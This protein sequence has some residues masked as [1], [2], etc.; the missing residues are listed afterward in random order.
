MR[1]ALSAKQ[2]GMPPLCACCGS[3]S[4][5]AVPISSTRVEGKRVIRTKTS[6]WNFPFCGRCCE[7]DRAWPTTSALEVLVLTVLTCGLYL[8]YYVKQR[9][10]A[11][12]LCAPACAPPR[13]AVSYLGWH[14]TVH[15][16]EVASD[17]FAQAFLA[18]NAKKVVGA[19]A[20]ARD[21]MSRPTPSSPPR[22]APASTPRPAAAPPPPTA[23][24]P[25][26]TDLREGFY[27]PHQSVTIAGRK[28]EGPLAYI[29]HDPKTADASTI[30]HSL[31]VAT[32]LGAEPLPY[33]P[34]YSGASPAQRAV[35]LD[36]H[37]SGRSD[38]DV[39][40]GYVFL[41]FYGLE[42]R[43]LVDGCDHEIVQSELRRL[44]GIYGAGNRSFRGYVTNLMAFMV[45]PGLATLPEYTVYSHLAPIAS[46]NQTA[47]AGLLAWLHLQGKPLPPSGAMLVAGSMEGAKRGAVIER[48]RTEL[49]NLFTLRYRER[50]ADGLRLDAAKRPQVI[51]YHPGSPSLLSAARQI[52][53]SIPSVLGRPAQ[54][55]P[56][57]ELWN[58]C[59]ADLKK[60]SFTRRERTDAPLTR[61]AWL[62]L[63][64]ELRAEYDHPDQDTWDEAIRALPR[65][66]ACHVIPAGRLAALAGIE[67]D[68]RVTGARLR[69]AAEMAAVLGYAV[70]PDARVVAKTVPV[71]SELAIWRSEATEVPDATLWKSVHTMLSLTLFVALADGEVA[72][73]EGRT[74]DGL[75]EDLFALDDAMRARVAALR[76]IFMRQPARVTT[77]A[78]KLKE[79]RSPGDLAKI[80]RVLVAIAAVD[81]VIVEGEHKALKNLYKAMD[82]AAS[83]LSAAIVASG[84]R[85]AG[86]DPV[87]VQAARAGL[88][89][90]T[91]PAPPGARAPALDAPA[92]AAIL[93]ETREVALLLSEV[94]DTDEEESVK[95]P[96]ARPSRPERPPASDSGAGTW[97]SLDARYQPVLR[98]LLTRPVWTVA[99]VRAIATREKMMP[100][101]ILEALN[102]WSDEHFGD[103]VIEEAGDWR[104]NARLLERQP[105]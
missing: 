15:H 34:T 104:I 26:L 96:P 42:R 29:G 72:D 103:H 73:E 2:L 74:V 56:L 75:I 64:P 85:L 1:I 39:P 68:E 24:T 5:T 12:S 19:D 9:Q 88:A 33:W 28:L 98:E 49:N 47:L 105:V 11:L 52:R 63:P 3:P 17:A 35:Y 92:I 71:A 99:E 36:W 94:L 62:A 50:F 81:G 18:T 77:L 100:G 84:A 61:E 59:V 4:I 58:E 46:D 67:V 48:A 55:G 10:R 57:V 21:L 13:R 40:I 80:G 51:Q 38:P 69:K 32:S 16:F 7:H 90:E 82:L 22:S 91:I 8:Y 83:E 93:A 31:R 43:V 101:A 41:H 97:P 65:V 20:T 86:D 70:E 30:V 54:F 23:P 44:L 76:T 6:T 53:V 78:K 66:G 87:P 25:H 79:S 45:L 95:P 60:L 37:A 89:G 102:A 14:G 27:A